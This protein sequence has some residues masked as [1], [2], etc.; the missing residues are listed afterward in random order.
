MDIKE[1]IIILI[2]INSSLAGNHKSRFLRIS[3][4]VQEKYKYGIYG[5][6]FTNNLSTTG[7]CTM[8]VSVDIDFV[9]M[10]PTFVLVFFLLI[11]YLMNIT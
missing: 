10:P 11:Y 4:V 3:C 9:V 5:N 1:E 2:C 8:Q 6:I 7:Y